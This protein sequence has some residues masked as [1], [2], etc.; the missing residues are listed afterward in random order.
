VPVRAL[1]IRARRVPVM[2][3]RGGHSRLVADNEY[4]R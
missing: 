3:V 2:A 1:R 4:R